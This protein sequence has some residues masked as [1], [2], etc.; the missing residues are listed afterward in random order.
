MKIIIILRHQKYDNPLLPDY[1]KLCTQLCF[2][3]PV[4]NWTR[5]LSL[6]YVVK[7]FCT[8]LTWLNQV[9]LFDSRNWN[10][11]WEAGNMIFFM[12]IKG[13]CC[14]R[15]FETSCKTHKKY[16][17]LKHA[18]ILQYTVILALTCTSNM[19]MYCRFSIDFYI[20]LKRTLRRQESN[21]HSKLLKYD[22]FANP[23]QLLIKVR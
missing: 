2:Y 1:W 19:M 6:V 22:N 4:I 18:M 3:L 10:G 9:D 17:H 15:Y 21:Q 23:A 12:S 13:C 5:I 7:N 16:F 20:Y 14:M 11:I 8:L